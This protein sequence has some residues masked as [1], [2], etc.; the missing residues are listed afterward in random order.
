M[1]RIS[2]YLSI[3][4]GLVAIALFWSYGSAQEEHI[5]DRD[6]P[7][8][9]VS[10]AHVGAAGVFELSASRAASNSEQTGGRTP[11]SNGTPVEAIISAGD[12]QP[13]A[14][15]M[16]GQSTIPA[17]NVF[18]GTSQEFGHIGNPQRQANIMGNYVTVNGFRSLEYS[19]N[20]GQVFTTTVG[21][22]R[23]RLTNPGDFNVELDYTTL[24]SGSNQL[25]ITGTE[26]NGNQT[27]I[28]VDIQYMPNQ[29]WPLP[30]TADWAN[31]TRIS[32]AGQPVDGLWSLTDTGVRPQ[33][34]SYDRLIAIGDSSWQ[35]YEV[36]VPIV[37]YGIDDARG[38]SFPSLG[39]GVG[40]IMNWD[41]HFQQRN[42]VPS[43]GW[44]EFGAIGW[45]RWSRDSD[46]VVT[47][48]GQMLTYYGQ[49]VATNSDFVL[50]Y[51]V[52]YRVK[53][54]TQNQANG[55]HL[56][57]YKI[58][59]ESEPEPYEWQM[60]AAGDPAGPTNGSMLLV[61]HHVDVEF[62]QVD[63]RPLSA[64]QPKIDLSVNGNGTVT[65]EPDLASYSY[66]Q[67]VT[68]T[69][70]VPVGEIVDWDGAVS[71]SALSHQ[72]TIERD[73]EITANFVSAE[74][75]AIDMNIVGNG[76]VVT[77]PSAETFA[78]G[79][80]ITTTALADE[81][82]IFAGWS[83]AISGYQNPAS[84]KVRPNEIVTATFVAQSTLTAPFSDDFNACAL[85]TSLWT[86]TDSVGDATIELDG[87]RMLISLPEGT[88]HDLWAGSNFAPRVMQPAT[89]GDMM[90]ETKFETI[91]SQRFQMAGILVEQDADNFIR[92][93]VFHDGDDLR[94]FTA[95]FDS[96]G[97][98]P[99]I[100]YNQPLPAPPSNEVYL[101]VHRFG[102]QWRLHYAFAEGAW[103]DPVV[104]FTHDMTI[105][106]TGVFAGNAPPN[107]QDDP[108]AHSVEID[109]F[110]NSSAPK[111]PEDYYQNGVEVITI[112]TGS[113]SVQLSPA[114]GNRSNYACGE[115]VTL[116]AQAE[117]GARFVGWSGPG[118]DSTDNPLDLVITGGAQSVAAEFEQA[119]Q[120]IFLPVFLK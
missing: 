55:E 11:L 53:M 17:L 64:I 85:D 12:T 72:F 32:D 50:E 65:V 16:A 115:T 89:D 23:R 90:V 9:P 27:S 10:E 92:F 67:Q 83:G 98:D 2:T 109:Y 114:S 43:N 36:E 108:P 31:A 44:Q 24:N 68:V 38:F 75:V 70:D 76:Q 42:E 107:G 15:S 66:G 18:Y 105:R 94:L 47:A 117:P 100:R 6:V 116:T 110:Y 46:Q 39:P 112:G 22:D 1:Q 35:D 69:A 74:P 93:D 33:V 104:T 3:Y 8:V 81:G 4:I 51:S 111:T 49:E 30:Y 7:A 5:Y 58:W 63:A 45:H 21:P 77:S 60:I 19:L 96:S 34:I 73:M 80:V 79:S 71:G 99:S 102:D 88:N 113:G 25:L 106:A 95:I 87:T 84:Y 14:A 40:V 86:I 13:Q 119:A 41:G 91:P 78:V 52:P 120:D 118:V 57:R 28:T 62:G 37:V 61:A 56:Y 59:K 29:Q 26:G 20:G 101:Q 103:S 54:S 97:A 82:Y 48:G